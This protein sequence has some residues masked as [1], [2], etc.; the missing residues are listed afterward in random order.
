LFTAPH[1]SSF[2]LFAVSSFYGQTQS[3]VRPRPSSPL[4]PL[5]LPCGIRHDL[6]TERDKLFFFFF[7]PDNQPCPS[8][9]SRARLGPPFFFPLPPRHRAAKAIYMSISSRPFP[10]F[11]E[12]CLGV[13]HGRLEIEIESFFFLSLLF[14]SGEDGSGRMTGKR[15]ISLSFFSPALPSTSRAYSARAVVSPPPLFSFPFF[16]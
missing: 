6:L 5:Q 3:R 2:L 7:F 13:E 1:P 4:L 10:L 8:Q 15:L 14:F 12:I 9:A 16:R 11:L